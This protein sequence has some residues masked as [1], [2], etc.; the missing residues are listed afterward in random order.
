M[1]KLYL[2]PDVCSWPR[3]SQKLAYHGVGV[4]GRCAERGQNY[5]DQ[6]TDKPNFSKIRPEPSKPRRSHNSSAVRGVEIH[7]RR[8]SSLKL[9]LPWKHVQEVYLQ[10]PWSRNHLYLTSC[11]RTTAALQTQSQKVCQ[12][13]KGR[14]ASSLDPRLEENGK[15]TENIHAHSWEKGHVADEICMSFAKHRHHCSKRMKMIF[16][17]GTLTKRHKNALWPIQVTE[18]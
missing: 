5:S 11:S 3:V 12:V 10:E 7:L 17:L 9:V 14:G 1:M 15:G 13:T 8:I 2:Y 16:P 6:P 4:G 18:F